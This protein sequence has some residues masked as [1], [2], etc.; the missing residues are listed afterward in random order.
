M[1]CGT[2]AIGHGSK[3]A[4][5]EH[6]WSRELCGNTSVCSILLFAIY[7]GEQYN[8]VRTGLTIR[9]ALLFPRCFSKQPACRLRYRR[10]YKNGGNEERDRRLG[11][12]QTP[13]CCIKIRVPLRCWRLFYYFCVLAILLGSLFSLIRDERQRR[14]LVWWLGE[15]IHNAKWKQ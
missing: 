13:H 5:H 8:M 2:I 11:R 12:R 3:S 15:I 1:I 14:N 7:G 9:F 4:C 6:I 10:N